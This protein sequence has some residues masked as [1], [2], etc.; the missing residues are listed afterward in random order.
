MAGQPDLFRQVRES[1]FCLTNSG[2]GSVLPACLTHRFAPRSNRGKVSQQNSSSELPRSQQALRL[3][4]FIVALS[5]LTE[6]LRNIL[7]NIFQATITLSDLCSA[8]ILSNIVLLI[9]YLLTLA[10][11]THALF[12]HHCSC[13]GLEVI[14]KVIYCQLYMAGGMLW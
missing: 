12:A 2:D 3:S 9:E 8:E 1:L 10:T 5:P 14:L 13:N 4:H 6:L 7:I 11:C